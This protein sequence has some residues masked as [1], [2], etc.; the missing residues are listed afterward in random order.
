MSFGKGLAL[1]H[2][3]LDL[4]DSTILA[5]ITLGLVNGA[6]YAALSLGLAVIFGMIDVVNFTHGAQ[7]MMGAVFAFLL[8]RYA[9]VGYWFA[10]ILSPLAV[11]VS[12]AA[13]ERV[14]IRRLYDVDP[15]YVLLLTFALALIIEG[16]FLIEVGSSGLPYPPPESLE[17]T[18]DLG[19]MFLPIYRAWVIVASA[20]LCVATWLIVERT[21]L[22]SYLRAATEKPEL[23][24]A[25]GIRVPLL[26]TMTYGCGVALAGLAGVLAA[27]I[28]QVNALM[29][30]NIIIVVFAVVVIGGLGS[31]K[32][33]AITGF[34]VGLLEGLT[35]VI[36]PEGSLT[37]IFLAMA[38][39]LLVRPAGL[40]GRVG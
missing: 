32:G 20:V 17:G 33:A 4:L 16:F 6:F 9:G 22:G 31:I 7:Y 11:G 35:K 3:L 39:V 15:V 5:Q 26:K 18:L 23:T 8:L 13:I 21:R 36:Y 12:G 10:L 30:T 37:V 1:M 2:N 25:F 40:F 27:P 14:L 28:L 34:L 19:F 38:I 29:G 24:R